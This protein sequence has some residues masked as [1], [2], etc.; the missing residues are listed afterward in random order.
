MFLYLDD[1]RVP[2]ISH[3][4]QRGV[5]GVDFYIVRNKKDFIDFVDKN[6]YEISFVSFDHDINSFEGDLEF[7]G[8]D[9]CQYLVDKCLESG[10]S[11]PDW[12]VHSDNVPGRN[13]IIGLILNFCKK[14]ENKNLEEFRYFHKGY[15][16]GKFI[17]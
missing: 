14:V 1:I 9:A 11:F 5:S 4:N 6:F 10:H 7:T 3:N 8:K 15:F 2:I 12:Y 16:K 13:N 17:C